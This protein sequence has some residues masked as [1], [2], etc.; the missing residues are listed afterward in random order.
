MLGYEAALVP[1]FTNLLSNAMKFVAPGILPQV[2][3]SATT[4]DGRVR[5]SVA[6][7]GIGIPAEAHARI[8]EVFERLPDASHYPGSG[9]GLAIVRRA[10]ARMGGQIG[11]ESRAGG[12]STF[13]FELAAAPSRPVA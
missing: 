8:F 9:V 11:L 13:W 10:V 3:V 6:D 7:N 1:A 2:N 12:G 5:V 4:Q